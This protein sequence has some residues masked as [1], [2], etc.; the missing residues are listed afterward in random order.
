MITADK[1][2]DLYYLVDADPV[3]VS[4]AAL[5]AAYW[6]FDG[7][8]CEKLVGKAEFAKRILGYIGLI[9]GAVFTESS[10]KPLSNDQRYRRRYVAG[11][12]Y[13]INELWPRVLIVQGR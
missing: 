6:P 2:C 1:S 11:P 9:L 7:G 3:T 5:A 12:P 13:S 8:V 4:F 10:S